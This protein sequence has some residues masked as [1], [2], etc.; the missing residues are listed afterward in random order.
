MVAYEEKKNLLLEM[1]AYASTDGQLSKKDYDFLFSLANDLNLGK[2]DF[3]DMLNYELP[4]LSEITELIRIQQFYRL[5]LFFQNEGILYKKDINMIFQLA[6]TMGLNTDIA[7][8]I[9]RRM[10]SS[11]NSI[12]PDDTLIKIYWDET[13]Y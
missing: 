5:L 11:P 12:I 2:G 4:K 13:I 7:K 6:I 1:I 10:K 9:L 3:I 8:E